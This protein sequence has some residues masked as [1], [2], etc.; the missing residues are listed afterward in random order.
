MVGT[1]V[2]GVFTAP[3][4][5]PVVVVVVADVPVGTG[6]RVVVVVVMVVLVFVDAVESCNAGLVGVV[7]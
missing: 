5:R 6:S 3:A 4:G 7:V 2:V 1:V